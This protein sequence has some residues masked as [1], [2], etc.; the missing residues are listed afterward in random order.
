MISALLFDLDGTLLDSD[1]DIFMPPYLRALAARLSP[2][3]P[4]ETLL[5]ALMASTRLMMRSR[6]RR[7][8][9]E[10]VFWADFLARVGRP[11]ADL[12]PLIDDFYR[13]DFATLKRYTSPK[14]EARPLVQAAFTAGFTV[15]IATQPVFPLSAVQQRLDWANTGDFPYALVTSY[16]NMHTAK[17]D[18]DFYREVCECIGH[19]PGSC[20]MVG[21]DADADIHPAAAAGLHTFW[22]ASHDTSPRA[23]LPAGR[24]GTLLDLH[25]RVER[26]TL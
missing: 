14:P 19:Q 26:R 25:R 1:M 20:L 7:Q 10:E 5:D 9:N 16:E 8:T 18:P 22:L 6:G 24:S 13:Q 12:A 4:P 3:V 17:P 23:D 21:N 2:V 11:R 15:A